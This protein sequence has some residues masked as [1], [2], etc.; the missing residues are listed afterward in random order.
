MVFPSRLIGSLRITVEGT[1]RETNMPKAE[2]F[3]SLPLLNQPPAT[4]QDVMFISTGSL[5]KLRIHIDCLLRLLMTIWA[6]NILACLKRENY[7]QKNH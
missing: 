4:G 6:I 5:F 3:R 7:F 1:K 2:D